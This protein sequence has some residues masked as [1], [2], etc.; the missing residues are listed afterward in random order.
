MNLPTMR[1]SRIPMHFHILHLVHMRN[2]AWL[3]WVRYDH[4]SSQVPGSA[5]EEGYLGFG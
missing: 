1:A 4:P 2:H 5:D 3:S